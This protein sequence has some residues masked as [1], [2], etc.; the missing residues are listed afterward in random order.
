MFCKKL[1]L[2][3]SQ[4]S[5]Q[6][7]CAKDSLLISCRST[8]FDFIKKEILVQMFSCEFWEISHK[9]FL[10]SPLDGSF[11]INTSSAYCPSTTL[12]FLKRCPT[13]FTAEYFLALIY[14][15]GTRV[16][17]TFQILIQTSIFNPFKHLRRSFFFEN[18]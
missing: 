13:Y 12:F 11:W 6:K 4:N 9:T 5:Q 1:F 17:S 14:R 7:L 15:F 3:T 8:E 2:Q 18:S 10:K 16:S